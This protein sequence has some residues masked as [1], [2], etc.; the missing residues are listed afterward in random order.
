MDR[1]SSEG[2]MVFLDQ[3]MGAD[4]G[5]FEITD[6]LGFT[7]SSTHLTVQRKNGN[8]AEE[9]RLKNVLYDRFMLL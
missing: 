8:G 3:V 9:G 1:L 4:A 2:S 6:L 7:V 5:Q